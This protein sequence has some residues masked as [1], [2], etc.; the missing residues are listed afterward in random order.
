MNEKI[1]CRTTLRLIQGGLHSEI[2]F[3]PVRIIAAPE[4]IPP[5]EL[6][7]RAYEEDT[8]LVMSA[9][10]KGCEPEVHP[11]RLMTELIETKPYRK[12]RENG[13]SG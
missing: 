5:F 2:S 10:P 9:D 11:I 12:F 6:N 8:W 13:H 7:A 3:G 4:N 1:A